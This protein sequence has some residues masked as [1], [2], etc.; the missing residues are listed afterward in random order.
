MIK[1]VLL[2]ENWLILVDFEFSIQLR[3][4]NN[5]ITDVGGNNIFILTLKAQSTNIKTLE[6]N[7][8]PFP[9]ITYKD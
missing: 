7:F 3:G 2:G 1:F 6:V 4:K 9:L 8:D 5:S